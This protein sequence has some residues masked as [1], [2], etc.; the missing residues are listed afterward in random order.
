MAMYFKVGQFE[1]STF[2]MEPFVTFITAYAII[3]ISNILSAGW[4]AIAHIYPEKSTH[5][6]PKI[7]LANLSSD[8]PSKQVKFTGQWLKFKGAEKLMSFLCY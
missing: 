8:K 3:I 2:K 5:R 6:P 4:T 7:G 1:L